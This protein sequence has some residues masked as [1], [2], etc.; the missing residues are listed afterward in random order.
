M[1]GAIVLIE[2]LLLSKRHKLTCF[3]FC[4]CMCLFHFFAHAYSVAG[5]LAVK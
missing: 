3:V 1:V 4:V 5:L 2:Y